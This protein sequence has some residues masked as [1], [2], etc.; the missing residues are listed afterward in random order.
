MQFI[1]DVTL[2]T[3]NMT[4][5][6]LHSVGISLMTSCCRRFQ[7]QVQHIF[8][9]NLCFVEI[10]HSILNVLTTRLTSFVSLPLTT[11]NIIRHV[12][13]YLDM[14]SFALFDF[15]YYMTIVFLAG[16]MMFSL[17]YGV[18]YTQQSNSSF[19]KLIISGSWLV[20]MV[21]CLTCLAVYQLTG[22]ESKQALKLFCYIPLDFGICLVTLVS[23]VYVIY[24]YRQTSMTMMRYTD[25]GSRKVF[26]SF[27]L[28]TTIFV[29]TKFVMFRFAPDIVYITLKMINK[30][31]R[32]IHIALVLSY[33][34]SNFIDALL[35]IVVQPRV[36]RCVKMAPCCKKRKVQN[37]CE[38]TVTA[39][40]VQFSSLEILQQEIRNNC[41]VEDKAAYYIPTEHEWI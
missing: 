21:V 14:V 38:V 16:D 2:L 5:F 37:S 8:I 34:F 30:E 17:R 27:P 36:R 7:H 24:R 26:T 9:T 3:L 10:M 29:L 35:F 32:V 18:K 39:Q 23:Y 6:C 40:Q 4:N 31:Y 22:V 19:A 1:F 28:Y 11:I 25:D 41:V 13:L 20:A 15:M 12:Q 33:V